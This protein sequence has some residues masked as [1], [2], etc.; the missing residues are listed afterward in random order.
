MKIIELNIYFLQKYHLEKTL[1]IIYKTNK[2]KILLIIIRRVIFLNISY[3][4]VFIFVFKEIFK[5]DK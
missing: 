5:I 4:F 1:N 3:Y 2:Y